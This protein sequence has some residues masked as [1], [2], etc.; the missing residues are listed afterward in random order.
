VSKESRAAGPERH[1][2]ISAEWDH[3]Q[4][5]LLVLGM[6]LLLTA[7][8]GLRIFTL[9]GIQRP[10]IW[11]FCSFGFSTAFSLLVWRLRSATP[12]AAALG[13]ILCLS[14][15]TRQ[16]YE[17]PWTHT[18]LP[19]LILLFLLTFA[20]TRYGRRHKETHG[21]TDQR[22]R[23]GRQTSQVMANLGI[24]AFLVMSPESGLFV[25]GLAALAEATADTVS[26]ELGQVFGGRTIL[27]TSGRSVPPGTD[28]A[29]SLAGT[30]SG[31]LSAALIAGIAASLGAVSP[32]LAVIVF[33]CGVAGLLFDSLLGATLERRGW[34]GNDLVNFASTCLAALLAWK[35]TLLL[36]PPLAF[37]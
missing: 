21:L 27:I 15:L 17:V 14:I 11:F 32:R 4:S 33:V 19:E 34:L 8:I 7:S 30:L 9:V 25:A 23:R 18:A 22:E 12:A 37:W 20:A 29:I 10:P 13:G 16:Y 6:G 1:R 5:F 24:A 2:A 36:E 35:L 28:G 31:M 3:R 26:S